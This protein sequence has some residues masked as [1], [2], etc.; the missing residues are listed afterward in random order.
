MVP[1]VLGK[2]FNPEMNHEQ[3]VML[4]VFE[5]LAISDQMKKFLDDSAFESIL[6]TLNQI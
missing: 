5:K 3:S 6:D 1:F 2:D 4:S